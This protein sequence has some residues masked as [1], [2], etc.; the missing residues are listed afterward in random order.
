[1]ER[2]WKKVIKSEGCW[3]WSASIR[4]TGYGQFYFK[5]KRVSAHRFSYELAHGM[6]PDGSVICHKCDNRKC[7]NPSHLFAGTVSEN[8]KDMVSKNKNR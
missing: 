5:G 2:F 3:E 8:N 1:M 4:S 7:V 6:I